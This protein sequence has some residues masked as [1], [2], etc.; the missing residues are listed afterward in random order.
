MEGRYKKYL[1]SR[2]HVAARTPKLTIGGSSLHP[3]AAPTVPQPRLP[4]FKVALDRA[5]SLS[6]AHCAAV[7]VEST[8]PPE[9]HASKLHGVYCVS[10]K[11]DAV[12]T[13]AIFVVM[14]YV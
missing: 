7:A 8:P 2:T 3:H 14:Y 13:P 1:E 5:A 12:S 10:F 9:N 6:V 11:I 4:L